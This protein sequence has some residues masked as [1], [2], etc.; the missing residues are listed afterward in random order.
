[1]PAF[2]IPGSLDHHHSIHGCCHRWPDLTD[3]SWADLDSNRI[4]GFV[5][6][7]GCT[8]VPAADNYSWDCTVPVRGTME[9]VGHS[10]RCH[11]MA[12]GHDD[13]DGVPRSSW[14]ETNV[15]QKPQNRPS[16]TPLRGCE[17]IQ[18]KGGP[19]PSYGGK[20]DGDIP[21][22]EEQHQNPDH[23]NNQCHP[24]APLVPC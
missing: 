8:G 2:R 22:Q 16:L 9:V 3:N 10:S 1:M 6:V 20:H 5:A 15:S 12:G 11:S 19:I 7:I 24:A 21:A 4:A 14:K 18:K 13:G 17:G 23:D